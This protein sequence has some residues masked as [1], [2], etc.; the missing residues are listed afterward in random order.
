MAIRT[1]E[2]QEI[3]C[4]ECGRVLNDT[5]YICIRANN[6]SSVQLTDSKGNQLYHI[7]MNVDL[8]NAE[9]AGTWFRK[10]IEKVRH[11]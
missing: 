3:Y 2:R 7:D 5:A 10:Q 4:D 9:C 8:C 11:A 1:V 6:N